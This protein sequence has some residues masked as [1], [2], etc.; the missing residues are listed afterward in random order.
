MPVCF[1]CKESTTSVNGLLIHFNIKHTDSLT[2]FECGE[3]G[4]NRK[5]STWNSLRSHLLG[6]NHNV[7]AWPALEQR[8]STVLQIT[9]PTNTQISCDTD[10]YDSIMNTISTGVTNDTSSTVTPTEYQSLIRKSC[11]TFVAKLYNTLS[12]PRK[13]I[14][15]IIE[16]N[17]FLMNGHI[18]VLKEKVL[19]HFNAFDSDNEA[20]ENIISMFHCLENQFD[21]L[22]NEYQ[23]MEYFTSCGNY[24]APVKYDIGKKRKCKNVGTCIAEKLTDVYGYY[25]PLRQ[26]LQKF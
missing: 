13:H 14:Q 7:T 4:C 16:A 18:S 11:D 19:S 2:V 26:T 9:E 20:I 22:R 15:S 6:S 8:V 5:W 10:Y 12:I 17:T 3:N 24:I 23:R 21:H 1:L 25:I